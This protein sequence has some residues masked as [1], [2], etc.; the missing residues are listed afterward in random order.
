MKVNLKIV[1][2]I[3]I[4]I[5]IIVISIATQ[6]QNATVKEEEKLSR[7][8][9]KQEEVSELSDEVKVTKIL[10]FKYK[11]SNSYLGNE[12]F[13][14]DQYAYKLGIFSLKLKKGITL[15]ISDTKVSDQL[16]T[17]ILAGFPNKKPEEMGLKSEADAY[18]ATQM[19]IQEIAYRTGEIYSTERAYVSSFRKEEKYKDVN[20]DVFDVAQDIVE[21][22]EKNP[23][24]K[25]QAITI[26][27][28]D[29][30]FEKI[31]DE[32]TLIGP[33]ELGVT[34]FNKTKMELN[35][36]DS[37]D[38][39][40]NRTAIILDKYGNTVF[41][42]S[43]NL[44]T[45]YVKTNYKGDM[46]LHVAVEGYARCARIYERSDYKFITSNVQKDILTKKL[47]INR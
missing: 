27:V 6:I 12:L 30:K 21:L 25:E 17:V 34:D 31:D 4:E 3:I 23:Y 24:T 38:K 36:T 40:V 11:D 14:D 16:F 7:T 10:S 28:E 18:L 5:S 9:V 2:I 35:L 39:E 37:D 41:E 47:L 15:K 26:D 46:K 32:Y 1:M 45:V 42:P 33:I 43:N 44:K 22:A 20:R 19:A 29:L 8:N 13:F